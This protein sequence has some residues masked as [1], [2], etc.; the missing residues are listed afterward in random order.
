MHIVSDKK[1]GKVHTKIH[2]NENRINSSTLLLSNE[3][4]TV[5]GNKVEGSESLTR[6]IFIIKAFT[7]NASPTSTLWSPLIA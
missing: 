1:L 3:N 7:I 4:A 5:E 2:H 6:K